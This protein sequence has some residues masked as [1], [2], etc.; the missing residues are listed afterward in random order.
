MRFYDETKPFY[1]ETDASG[2]GLRASLL[3]KKVHKLS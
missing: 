1:L 2:L 3:Q